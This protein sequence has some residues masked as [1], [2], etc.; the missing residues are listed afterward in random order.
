MLKKCKKALL[1]SDITHFADTYRE[2]ADDL[3]V[4]LTVES[5]WNVR[6]RLNQEVVILGSKFLDKLNL[7]YFPQAVLI[8]KS[9]EKPFPYIQQGITRFICDYQNTKELGLA[10]FYDMPVY[11]SYTTVELEEMLKGFATHSFVVGEY[12][13]DFLADSFKF[14][15][16]QIYLAKS[17]KRYL[18]EWL[19]GGHKDNKRR[20]LLC[21]LRKKFGETFLSDVDRFGHIIGGKDE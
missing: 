9:D 4:A 8:L 20:M 5:D 19:L 1:L 14:R 13:F 7:D 18:A 10:F 6:Y 11:I 21:T 15:G 12:N 2:I 17:Q 16:K 3:G